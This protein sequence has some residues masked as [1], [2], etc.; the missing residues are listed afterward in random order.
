M[1]KRF[2]G[3]LLVIILIL[4]GIFFATKGSGGNSSATSAQPTNHVEG[5]GSTGVKLVEYGDYECPYCAEYYPV[6]K[7]VVAAYSPYIYFQFRNLPLTAIHPNAFAG[8]RAAEAAGM[9]GKFW[10]M[11][12]L[13]Y[14]NNDYNNQTGWVSSTN[15]LDD[16]FVGFAQ[17]LGL[18]IAKFKSDFSSSQVNNAINADVSAF[19]KTGAQEATPTF[20]LDGI[21]I[22]PSDT[23]KSF[24][25]F[26]NAEIKKKT[27]SVPNI[28]NLPS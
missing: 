1:D 12:D 26:L 19:S 22:Q 2:W 25:Q 27:G 17:Q 18:N 16:Y 23:A 9:Q 24:E 21:Q 5:K 15:A 7:E 14:Q 28:P 11:H 3:I 13:L 6:I 10:Q 4:G 20:F 8:A